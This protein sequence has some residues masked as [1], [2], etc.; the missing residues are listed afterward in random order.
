MRRFVFA[1]IML[2]PALVS[3]QWSLDSCIQYAFHN[4]ISIQQSALNLEITQANEL[5]SL[6]NMLPSLNAQA[7]HGYNWGQRIDPF[8][9]Q[10]A[11]ET[12][13]GTTLANRDR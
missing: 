9:N 10:F 12:G 2:T 7:T 5:L 11:T 4:N 1:L 6:G 8:T 3:G 13:L